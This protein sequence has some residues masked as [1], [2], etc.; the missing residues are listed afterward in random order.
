MGSL[1]VK[2]RYY[3]GKLLH[4]SD[5]VREQEYGNAKLEF[6]NRKFHGWGIIQGLGVRAGEGGTLRI[7]AGSAIDQKGRIIVVPEAVTVTAESLEEK[8]KTK[9]GGDPEEREAPTDG[10]AHDFIL[11]IRYEE[12]AVDTERSLLSETEATE[13][14]R[15]AESYGLKAYSLDQWEQIKGSG[16]ISLTEERVLYEDGEVRL[17]LRI[18]KVVPTDSIFRICIQ[19]RAL[20]G[21]GVSTGWRCTV[22]LQGAFFLA[23][24][25]S[26]QIMEE[27]QTV[28]SGSLYQEWQLC[29]EEYGKQTIAMELSRL[30]IL[31][32]GRETVQAQACQVYIDAALSYEAAVR[33]RLLRRE[34]SRSGEAWVPLA[35]IGAGGGGQSGV[36]VIADEPGLRRQVVQSEETEC[37]RRGAQESGIIDIRWRGLLKSLQAPHGGMYLPGSLDPPGG[38]GHP[39]PPA[40]PRKAPPERSTEPEPIGEQIHRGVA[41]ISV[42]RHYR[43]GDTL[44]SEEISHG[45]PGEEVLLWLER[46]YEEPSYAY[47]EKNSTRHTAIHGADDLFAEGWYSGWEIQRQALRQEIEA[48]TFQIALIL[49]KGRRKKRS[50][51]VAVSWTA[52]RLPR[53]EKQGSPLTARSS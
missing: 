46:L 29:T 42:P 6:L 14:A 33:E 18:P 13:V 50:R 35:R 31:R 40:T 48:G 27:Q 32:Q 49:S 25:R 10:A 19:A 36:H 8:S 23:T 30:E 47:W 21:G 39:A 53:P 24:G 38:S 26:L 4:A 3:P 7:E 20:T 43:R 11:G 51:E 17:S 45:F 37:I 2:N 52:V 1:F 15:I 41:V 34:E 22:K 28:L 5:F 44:F 9:G 12:K 16:E